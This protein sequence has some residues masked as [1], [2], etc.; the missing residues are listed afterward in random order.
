M[1]DVAAVSAFVA[2]RRDK[3]HSPATTLQKYSALTKAWLDFLPTPLA[4][5]TPDD[6]EDF[7]ARPRRG[8]KPAADATIACEVAV[9]G[10]FYEWAQHRLHWPDNPAR[11]AGRPRVHNVD[12]SPVDDETWLTVWTADLP[13]AARVALGL[14]YYC[15]LRR[16]EVASLRRHHLKGGSLVNFVRKGGGSDSMN[17]WDLL[18]HWQ[19][20]LP[21]LQPL[22]LREPLVRLATI[23]DD[24]APLLAWAQ[25]GAPK[26][27][28]RRMSRW[29]VRTG[30]AS[31]SFTP[32]ACRHS[33]A[34]NLFRTGVD[35]RVVSMLCNHGSSKVTER[36]VKVAGTLL[37]AVA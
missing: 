13:D 25:S 10:S 29:L 31:D 34:T 19:R 11:L 9:L 23:G 12:P 8:G 30:L 21:H 20:H 5:R 15:G 27:V 4:E 28:N 17:V 18:D 33:F 22:R 1:D 32:H 3:R 16:A 35:P 2:W 6:V 26:R 14:M 7:T 36:Y 24:D 37:T